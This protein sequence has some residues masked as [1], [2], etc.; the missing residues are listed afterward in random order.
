MSEIWNNRKKNQCLIKE[1]FLDQVEKEDIGDFD[2]TSIALSV[3]ER[4]WL[5]VENI[6]PKII[7]LYRRRRFKK[8]NAIF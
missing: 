4:Q 6:K 2:Q 8:S 3:G 7:L 5:Q 1:F